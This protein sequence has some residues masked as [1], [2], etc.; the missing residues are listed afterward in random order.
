MD[1]SQKMNQMVQ[2]LMKL[3][4]LEFGNQMLEITSFDLGEMIRG[5]MDATGVLFEQKEGVVEYR[6]LCESMQ[7]TGDEFMIEEVLKNYL[8]NAANHLRQG[9]KVL[10]MAEDSTDNR[11]RVSVYN[12]GQQIPEEFLDKVWIKFFKVDKARTR[13]YGGS[14]IGLSIVKAIMEQHGCPYGVEN[15]EDGV[16]FWFEMNREKQSN[17][18]WT[19]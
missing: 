12:Q 6:Q 8:S 2:K 4:Q 11:I 14:G 13:E 18:D 9:G 7:V 3:N 17:C 16:M 1:E 15:K 10:V 5:M 19:V